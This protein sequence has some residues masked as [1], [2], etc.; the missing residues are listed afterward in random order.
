MRIYSLIVSDKFTLDRNPNPVLLDYV[1][2]SLSTFLLF[3]FSSFK[4]FLFKF[5]CSLF[6]LK[7]D[8]FF[9]FLFEHFFHL[10]ELRSLGDAWLYLSGLLLNSILFLFLLNFVRLVLSHFNLVLYLLLPLSYL[11]LTTHFFSCTR[12]FRGWHEI[13]W[14][15]DGYLVHLTSLWI[16][17]PHA[18]GGFVASAAPYWHSNRS[19]LYFSGRLVKI[20]LVTVVIS[21]RV[22]TSNF[23]FKF[24][25]ISFKIFLKAFDKINPFVV[26]I[27]KLLSV[28]FLRQLSDIVYHWL[29]TWLFSLIHRNNYLA[30]FLIKFIWIIGL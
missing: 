18:S 11:V 5:Q 3:C 27:E 17:I 30:K 7:F 1:S 26:A 23:W 4:L 6:F 15:F 29:I 25:Q 13:W 22:L 12:E 9:F 14:R 19:L 21:I 2:C 28:F 20:L 16:L 10:N 8:L 24:I